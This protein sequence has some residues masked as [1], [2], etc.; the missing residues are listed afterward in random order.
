M[1]QRYSAK[2]VFLKISQSSKEMTCTRV[3]FLIK[4]RSGHLEVFLRKCVLKIC[5]K[6]IGE[7]QCQSLIS[8]KLLCNFIEITLRHGC[9]PV[10]LLHIF[11]TPFSKEHFWVAASET[12]R[13]KLWRS[14]FAVNFVKVLFDSKN[15]FI[16]NRE[17][18]T[19][20]YRK[21]LSQRNLAIKAIK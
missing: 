20:Y 7:Q 1:T 6:F 4:Y 17:A 9:F 2:K 21:I 10:N 12:F 15:T 5:S 16:M 11:W 8:I 3:F 14:C 18:E 19:Q 13:L